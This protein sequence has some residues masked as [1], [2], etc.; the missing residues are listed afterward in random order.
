MIKPSLN[1][2]ELAR[3]T[4][5][6]VENYAHLISQGKGSAVVAQ[7]M[8]TISAR[9]G[10]LTKAWDEIRQGVQEPKFPF[11]QSAHHAGRL[12]IV[13]AETHGLKKRAPYY[14]A[15]ADQVSQME[16]HQAVK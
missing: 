9:S 13:W 14:Q 11:H 6:L 5:L 1:E 8:D 7:L 12:L 2:A 16:L 4:A 10:R 15:A 3:D